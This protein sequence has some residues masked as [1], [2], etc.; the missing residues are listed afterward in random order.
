[1]LSGLLT[2]KVE[3]KFKIKSTLG[4]NI[5]FLESKIP[6]DIALLVELKEIE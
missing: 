5:P 3:Q 2:K 4:N 6:E 1:M